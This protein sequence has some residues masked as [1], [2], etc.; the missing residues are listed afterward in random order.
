MAKK[1]SWKLHPASAMMS[2]GYNPF[3]SEGSVVCPEFHSTT[4]AFKTAEEGAECFSHPCRD[5]TLIYGRF[6]SPNIQIFEERLALWEQA[7]ACASFSSGMSAIF[8]LGFEF[9]KAGD[10]VLCSEPLY[11]GS[12]KL[13]EQIF[14]QKLGIKYVGFKNSNFKEKLR[15]IIK[16][17]EKPAMVF[18]ESPANPTN[19][20]V[21]IA[22]CRKLTKKY[23]SLIVVDNTFLGPIFQHPLKLGAD[24][25]MYSA[26]KYIG[27]HSDVLAGACVGS[28]KY[29][30]ALKQARSTLGCVLSP[31]SAS[32]LLRSLQTLEL[33][34]NKEMENACIIAK[35][36]NAHPKISKVYFLD[37]LGL[38]GA[39]NTDYQIYLKQCLAPGSVISFDIK[40]GQKSAY[41]FL[42]S[43]RLFK[44]AVSLGSTESLAQHPYSMT[45]AGVPAEHKLAMGITQNMI[46]LSIGIEHH[47]DLIRDLEQALAAC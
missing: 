6:N 4:Y 18:I 41:K 38:G 26:T 47:D 44:L 12:T 28:H 45:H 30:D 40:G 39:N 29:I 14:P 31:D 16:S 43:L 19:D 5:S 21:D 7:E 11:G 22:M 13:F 23:G 2:H 20:L 10:V 1:P 33:R 8:T 36:L 15:E 27:G 37:L 25:S 24:I 17:G 46:R 34:M 32:R 9:L 42:N 35:E 3:Q